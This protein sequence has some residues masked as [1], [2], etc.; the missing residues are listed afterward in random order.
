[1]SD[2]QRYRINPMIWKDG[3]GWVSP[4][5]DKPTVIAQEQQHK[6]GG[7]CKWREVEKMRK[8]LEEIDYALEL[9][10]DGYKSNLEG[11]KV[12]SIDPTERLLKDVRKLKEATARIIRAT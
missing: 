10:L 12:M 2:I 11:S 4:H 5:R 3:K 1:M 6:K 8:Q 9:A 7:W